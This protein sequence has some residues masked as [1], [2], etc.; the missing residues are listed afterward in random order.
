MLLSSKSFIRAGE[1]SLPNKASCCCT[2]NA[3]PETCGVAKLVPSASICSL[4]GLSQ[5]VPLPPKLLP[6]NARVPQIS[7][8]GATI[9]NNSSVFVKPAITSLSLVA[10]TE[11]TLLKHA[12]QDMPILDPALPEAPTKNMPWLVPS[13]INP[14]E[15][16]STNP[17]HELPNT[18]PVPKLILTTEILYLLL[19][20]TQYSN[21]FCTSARSAP[22]V[23]LNALNA[24]IFASGATPLNVAFSDAIMPATNV[25]WP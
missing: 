21:A 3:A 6:P 5:I 20:S 15:V 16:G 19:C 22:P 25:P 12:G 10:P 18:L 24:T 2:N 17:S 11:V 14:S 8:P 13:L 4:S 23:L 9:S 1:V 7:T